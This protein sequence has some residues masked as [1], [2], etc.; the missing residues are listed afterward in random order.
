MVISILTIL[1][2]ISLHIFPRK[3]REK[4][5]YRLKRFFAR[6]RRAFRRAVN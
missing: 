5:I 1:F 2:I 6:I 3:I 4:V